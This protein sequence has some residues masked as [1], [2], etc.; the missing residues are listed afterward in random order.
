[1]TKE[2]TVDIHKFIDTQKFSPYQMMVV[3]LC[4][5][6]VMMDGFDTQAIGYVAPAIIKSWHVSRPALSPVFSAGLSARRRTTSFAE[7]R[8][9]VLETSPVSVVCVTP[10]EGM[11]TEVLTT[12]SRSTASGGTL[13]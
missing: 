5:M 7:S 1:M 9:S 12:G 4:A 13:L 8:L 10:K 6:V 2:V 11:L 3:G